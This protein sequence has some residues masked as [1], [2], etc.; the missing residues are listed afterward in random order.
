VASKIARTV[1]V[2]G[3]DRFDLKY[4]AGRLPHSLTMRGIEL[5]GTQVI[6]RVQELLA[7]RTPASVG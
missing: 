2:L 7:E 1:D 3:L 4:S 5:Y 6:P